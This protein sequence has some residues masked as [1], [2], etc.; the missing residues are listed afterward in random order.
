MGWNEV[1]QTTDSKLFEGIKDGEYFYF[2]HSYYF[3]L[4]DFTTSKTIHGIEVSA[5]VE[6][7]NYYGVQFHPEKS[8]EAGLKVLQNFLAI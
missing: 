4:G 6:K 1:Y 8:G 7:E 2:A 3:S 5:S